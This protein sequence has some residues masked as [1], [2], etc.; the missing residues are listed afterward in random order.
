MSHAH[1]NS[2]SGTPAGLMPACTYIK[3][4]IRKKKKEHV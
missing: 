4:T 3:K 2:K 1:P